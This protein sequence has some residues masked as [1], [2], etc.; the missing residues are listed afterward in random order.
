MIMKNNR[1]MSQ[2]GFWIFSFV[3]FIISLLFYINLFNTFYQQDEWMALGYFFGYGPI[4]T[5]TGVP[6]I[7]LITGEGRPFIWPLHVLFY[8]LLPFQIWPLALFSVLVQPMIGILVFII[9]YLLTGSMVGAWVAGLFF[10]FSYNGSQAVSWFATSTVT[11]SSTFFGLLSV[12]CLLIYIRNKR[13]WNLV[14][15]QMSV[16]FSYFFK[17]SGFMFVLFLP[18]LYIIMEK[19]KKTVIKAL[20][21]FSPIIIYFSF[22][23]VMKT[24]QL[25]APV[26]QDDKFVGRSSGGFLKIIENAL[27]YPILSFSQLFIPFSLVKKINPN[28]AEISF[29]TDTIFVGLSIIL[30]ILV[31]FSIY[32]F[33]KDRKPLIL[34][35]VFTLCSFVPYAVL[36]RGASYLSLRYFYVGMIGASLLAGTY[37]SILWRR[38]TKLRHI[39]RVTICGFIF[40]FM[41]FYVYKNIQFISRD[42]QLQ[43]LDARERMTILNEIKN[44][45]PVLPKNPVFYITGDHPGYYYIEN[46]KVPF[47]QGMGYTLMIWYYPNGEI[48]NDFLR[49]ESVFFWD[50]NAEGYR[51]ANEYGFGY[52]WNKES[53]LSDLKKKKFSKDQIISFYYFGGDRKLKDMTNMIRNELP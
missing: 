35:L 17:E 12:I 37:A 11:L 46:Q 42:I 39:V 38:I 9:A 48:Q 25:L 24:T 50:I 28:F 40:L 33:K 7:R 30:L 26:Y 51:E 29:K 13:I 20:H 31:A 14:A 41:A 43:V 1:I 52:Y 44:L 6:F 32:F 27:F 49:T 15:A 8:W 16:I 3:S 2:R 18:F 4:G 5:L 47:Q 45:Y 19:G 23:I 10:L 36:E 21:I 53:L 22:A 34:S